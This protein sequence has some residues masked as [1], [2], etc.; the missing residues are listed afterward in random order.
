MDRSRGKPHLR[1]NAFNFGLM[2][3]ASK[4][5]PVSYDGKT[6]I[7]ADRFPARLGDTFVVTIES[8]RAE[9]P[10]GVGVA[11]GVEVFGERVTRAVVWEYFSVVPEMRAAT[12]SSLP[13]SFDVICRNKQGSLLFYNMTEFK[14]RQEWWYGGSCMIASDIPGG[15]RYFCN[16][17]ELDDDFDD[18][19][20]TVTRASESGVP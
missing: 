8:T 20:F 11:E 14:G 6:L 17:F 19:V 10:Q 16:D 15:R 2:F 9:W 3:R 4:G 1:A 12:R 5:A 13:F 7:M 18:L